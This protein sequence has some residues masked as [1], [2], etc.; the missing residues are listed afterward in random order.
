MAIK[1]DTFSRVELSDRDAARFVKHIREDAPNPRA[2]ASYARGRAIL[3][4]VLANQSAS[5]R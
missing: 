2:K 1:S 4:Q 3:G 5:A